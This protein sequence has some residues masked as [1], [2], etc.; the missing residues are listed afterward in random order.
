MKLTGPVYVEISDC[1]IS[2][3]TPRLS[4][5]MNCSTY[6]VWVLFLSWHLSWLTWQAFASF[7]LLIRTP[8]S[9]LKGYL[10]WRC[11][12]ASF[13][14]TCSFRILYSSSSYAV[15]RT[16]SLLQTQHSGILTL[17]CVHLSTR[18]V[19]KA[20]PWKNKPWR[21]GK[22]LLS[23]MCLIPVTMDWSF[24]KD[25]RGTYPDPNLDL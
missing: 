23:A 2:G 14:V 4:I 16:V 17:Q 5:S 11:P 19:P 21:G 10:A 3:M 15:S 18:E 8:G 13:R 6:W 24:P 22:I 25:P 9:F 1:E 12:E 7:P 20:S